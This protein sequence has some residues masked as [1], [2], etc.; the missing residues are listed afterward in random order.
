VYRDIGVVDGCFASLA[1]AA[2]TT[3]EFETVT[4]LTMDRSTP[5]VGGVLRNTTAPF[6]IAFSDSGSPEY[7]YNFSRCI[8]LILT[9]ME[10]PGRYYLAITTDPT[11]GNIQLVSCTLA[12]R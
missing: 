11:L 6:V 3:Y 10:K 4:A 9:M 7:L 1:V 12:L 5:S 2:P 8:P